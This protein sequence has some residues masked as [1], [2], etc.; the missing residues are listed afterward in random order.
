MKNN[1]NNDTTIQDMINNIGKNVKILE[2]DG[3]K[4]KIVGIYIDDNTQAEY[5]VKYYH[6]CDKKNCY[7]NKNE[8]ELI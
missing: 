8:I 2:L 5:N 1:K 7:F 4:G 6:N 3:M